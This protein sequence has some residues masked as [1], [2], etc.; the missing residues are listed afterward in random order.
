[1]DTPLRRAFISILH[2]ARSAH[3]Y[4]MFKVGHL[5][6]FQAATAFVVIMSHET[7]GP[8]AVPPLVLL[9]MRPAR[10]WSAAAGVTPGPAAA[11]DVL[12]LGA[13][14][15]GTETDWWL[16]APVDLAWRYQTADGHIVLARGLPGPA[17]A[18]PDA[19]IKG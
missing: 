12:Q 13:L 6:L 19:L 15:D 11:A 4:A 1:M 5:L 14:L 17:P 2:S 16:G 10:G 18:Q 7:K 9:S 8:A 3:R